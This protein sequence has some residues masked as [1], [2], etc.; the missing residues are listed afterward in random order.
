MTGRYL[1][2][3]N[4]VIGLFN[5]DA[6]IVKWLS[7]V[8]DV[9]VCSI[10][11]GELYY[12]AMKSTRKK[13]NIARVDAFALSSSVLE[14][15]CITAK[16]YGVIKNELRQKGAPIPENDVWIAAFA[17]QYGLT[18]VTADAHFKKTSSIKTKLMGIS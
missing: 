6:G 11:M 4:I 9:H 5:G 14:S 13:E 16:E 10:V 7:G 3:T 15:D 1:L 2:D 17:K 12:G 8:V 18:L